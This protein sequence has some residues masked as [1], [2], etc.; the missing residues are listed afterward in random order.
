MCVMRR[1][2]TALVSQVTHNFASP[3]L[4]PCIAPIQLPLG[5]TRSFL[6]RMVLTNDDEIRH[7]R[8]HPHELAMGPGAVVPKFGHVLVTKDDNYLLPHAKGECICVCA[9]SRNPYV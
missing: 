6:G 1:M 2:R 9:Q 4:I 5:A 7:L 3:S 8:E